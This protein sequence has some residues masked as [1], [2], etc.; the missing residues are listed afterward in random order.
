MAAIAERERSVCEDERE[1]AL[2]ESETKGCPECGGRVRT[3]AHETVCEDCGLVVSEEA[4]DRGPEWRSFEDETSDSRRV[5]APNTVARHDRGIGAKIGRD[6]DG[7]GRKLDGS[8]KTQLGRL[9]RE[10]RR[11]KIGSKAERN[12][13]TGFTE[14]R[15]MVAALGLEQSVRDQACQL[16]RTAQ[17]R[18][19]L[20]GR[21]IEAIAAACVYAVCRLNEHPRTFEELETL[22]KVEIA[23]VE[24]GYSVLNRELGLPVPPAD[25]MQYLP[26]VASAVGLDSETERRAREI[27]E[28][29]EREILEGVHPGGVAAG[30]L[31][32]AG[33]QLGGWKTQEELGEA[34]GVS[35]ATVRARYRELK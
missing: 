28:A 10:N 6:R 22:S 24:N 19:L 15:R 26:K 32:V 34:A 30:A 27:I 16:F 1:R 7:N 13:I 35:E 14:I 4:I 31:Y 12:R 20:R 23:R 2:G 11:A 18:G 21:S 3:N 33:R 17:D 25:P 8:K 29:A 9:R 5:G